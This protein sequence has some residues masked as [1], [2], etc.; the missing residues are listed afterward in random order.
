MAR[1]NRTIKYIKCR[2]NFFIGGSSSSRTCSASAEQVR[3]WEA[4]NK[5]LSEQGHILT[6][7]RYHY[8]RYD[9]MTK[10]WIKEAAQNGMEKVEA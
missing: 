1:E 5:K 9:R 10:N 3:E 8:K 4:T 2:Q 6:D 7:E